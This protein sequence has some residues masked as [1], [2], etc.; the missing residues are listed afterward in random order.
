VYAKHPVF[1]DTTAIVTAIPTLLAGGTEPAALTTTAIAA[2]LSSLGKSPPV[3][4][5]GSVKV[6][7]LGPDGEPYALPAANIVDNGSWDGD[8][9]GTPDG[10]ILYT[11]LQAPGPDNRHAFVRYIILDDLVSGYNAAGDRFFAEIRGNA[12]PAANAEVQI[13]GEI[14]PGDYKL[15][16]DAGIVSTKPWIVR[17]RYGP[18]PVKVVAGETTVVD[19]KLTDVTKTLSI[20]GS[21]ASF[22]SPN[23]FQ[24]YA[25]STAP[26]VLYR[27]R[28]GKEEASPDP[29]FLSKDKRV[30]VRD[31]DDFVL[32]RASGEAGEYSYASPAANTLRLHVAAPNMQIDITTAT[33]AE[34][35]G[36]LRAGIDYGR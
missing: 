29:D 23:Q 5:S 28:F 34:G 33:I 6:R 12:T 3:L 16:Y 2:E 4:P 27:I 32:F 21:G 10:A 9:D 35:N 14:P 13:A 17:D 8:S 11:R 24:W 15:R 25:F 18:T 26:N 22:K 1:V 19:L 36:A 30:S 20:S 7:V 31:K